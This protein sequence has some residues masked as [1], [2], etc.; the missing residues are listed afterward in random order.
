MFHPFVVFSNCSEPGEVDEGR[1]VPFTGS[2]Q[3]SKTYVENCVTI[4]KKKKRK[5]KPY[6]L[7]VME[8]IL[9]YVVK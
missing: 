1:G 2:P 4:K 3:S 6:V 9:R 7:T 8:I 5:V